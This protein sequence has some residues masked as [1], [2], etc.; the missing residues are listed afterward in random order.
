MAFN[1]FSEDPGVVAWNGLLSCILTLSE[2]H[3]HVEMTVVGTVLS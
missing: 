2:G 1:N 3:M